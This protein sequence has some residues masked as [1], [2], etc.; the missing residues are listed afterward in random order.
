MFVALACARAGVL[1]AM[2]AAA[3]TGVTLA[4]SPGGRARMVSGLA[5]G[6]VVLG[7][8]K[9]RRMRSGSQLALDVMA[10]FTAVAVCAPTR[11]EKVARP[12]LALLRGAAMTFRRGGGS[13][14]GTVPDTVLM[15][16]LFSSAPDV[17]GEHCV[18]C[19]VGL[20][21]VAVGE[22]V[23]GRDVERE[24]VNL[25]QVF[26]EERLEDIDFARLCLQSQESGIPLVLELGQGAF[27]VKVDR[28]KVVDVVDRCVLGILLVPIIDH[29]E[30]HTT[31]QDP[32]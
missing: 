13:V 30:N 27:A 7:C 10:P 4:A 6:P 25:L 24:C 9:R 18:Q 20:V 23:V 14:P 21:D 8:R 26:V 16:P 2:T 5:I 12:L 3:A 1:L 32:T 11:L 29:T 17:A 15:I 19:P 22:T 28:P 31:A